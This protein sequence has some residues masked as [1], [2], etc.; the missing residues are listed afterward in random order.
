MAALWPRVPHGNTSPMQPAPRRI[1]VETSKYI[2]RTMER[3]DASERWGGWLLDP[4]TARAL[5]LRPAALALAQLH[6]YIDRFDNVTGF[7]IGIFEKPTSRLVGFRAIYVDHAKREFT[8][9]LLIGEP[10]ARGNT[11]LVESTEALRPIFFEELDLTASRCTV[12]A[13]NTL[14]LALL[15]RRGWTLERTERKASATG[16][17]PRELHHFRLDRETWRARTRERSAPT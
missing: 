4:E 5:N 2:V 16:G 15:A 6:A 7:L 12:L 17:A 9:N 14:M 1:R 8:D 11:A 13:D 3:T 10:D